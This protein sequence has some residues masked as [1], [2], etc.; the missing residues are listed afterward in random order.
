MP[1]RTTQHA[2]IYIY[3]VITK[4]YFIEI[5]K[6][7]YERLFKSIK[8]IKIIRII[9]SMPM[10]NLTI[11]QILIIATENQFKNQLMIKMSKATNFS[12]SHLKNVKLERK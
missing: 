3:K 8:Q 12:T 2:C 1:P 10:K 6:K 9:I 5:I 4:F 11:I 7:I